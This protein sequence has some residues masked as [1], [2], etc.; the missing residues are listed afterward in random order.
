MPSSLPAPTISNNTPN[1]SYLPS[2]QIGFKQLEA[3]SLEAGLALLQQD[4]RRQTLCTSMPPETGHM[5]SND[6]SDAGVHQLLVHAC[7]QLHSLSNTPVAGSSATSIYH[8][9]F[10]MQPHGQQ[11]D[12]PTQV[13]LGKAGFQQDEWL[14]TRYNHVQVVG[15]SAISIHPW[16]SRTAAR[17]TAANLMCMASNQWV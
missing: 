8:I 3:L 15:S 7:F 4:E 12:A 11:Q 9:L 14:Q 17:C 2:L 6:T 1:P 5:A 13:G 10:R 16:Q